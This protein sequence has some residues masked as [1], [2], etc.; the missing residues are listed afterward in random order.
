MENI[1]GMM[2]AEFHFRIGQGPTGRLTK[3]ATKSSVSWCQNQVIASRSF[4]HLL[5]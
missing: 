2:L 1:D 4:A 3:L 5:T